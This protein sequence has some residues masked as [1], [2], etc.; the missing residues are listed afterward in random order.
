MYRPNYWKTDLLIDEIA[1]ID[2]V[3]SMKAIDNPG[4]KK[5]AEEVREMLKESI[6]KA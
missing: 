5:I 2:P 1:A 3:E 6:E 4:L